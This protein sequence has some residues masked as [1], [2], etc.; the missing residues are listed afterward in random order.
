M[1]A[2]FPPPNATR[3][4]IDAW[5]SAN[6]AHRPTRSPVE[7]IPFAG[8]EHCAKGCRGWDGSSRRCDC[9]NRRVYWDKSTTPPFAR[10]D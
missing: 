4:E 6:A 10:A 3:E 8:D 7:W 5:R 1:S 9:G 2:P